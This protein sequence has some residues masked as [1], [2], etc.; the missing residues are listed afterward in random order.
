MG[1]CMLETTMKPNKT[2]SSNLE[3]RLDPLGDG[4]SSVELVRIS[5]S[6][7][8]I[9]NAARVSYGKF[10]IELSERDV[11]LINFLME[12]DHTTPFEHNQLSFRVKCPRYV[13]LQWMRHR[14]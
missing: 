13:S 1:T 3:Q 9:A 5:G 12:H 2:T 6:D 4:L 7:I 8:D 14:M 10:V 11:K